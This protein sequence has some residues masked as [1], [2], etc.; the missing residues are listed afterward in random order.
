LS[1][2]TGARGGKIVALKSFGDVTIV[3]KETC[4]G[5]ISGQYATDTGLLVSLKYDVI[6]EE[7]GCISHQSLIE[8][9]KGVIFQSS[10]GLCLIGK[11]LNITFIGAPVEK[12]RDY[13]ITSA[14]ML[15]N[16]QT[17]VF[18]TAD[19]S[20]ICMNYGK[21]AWSTFTG[22]E[23]ISA[24]TVG[25]DYYMLMTDGRILKR[26]TATKTDAGFSI[27]SRLK[28]QWYQLG[29]IGGFERLYSLS[30]QGMV[31]GAH[32]LKVS[33]YYDFEQSPRENLLYATGS[34]STFGETGTFGT[35]II[36]QTKPLQQIRVQPRWQKCTS[37][38]VELSEWVPD[39]YSPDANI[40]WNGVRLE[41]GIKRGAYKFDSSQAAKTLSG[42]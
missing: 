37:V 4:I 19:N 33:M 12:M 23:A 35:V 21:N 1:L 7:V 10:R 3:L 31:E 42:G 34:L 5:V 30:M 27:I 17:V 41:I 26:N 39:D 18:T 9:D 16:I 15:S 24:V 40:V 6:S 14:S 8:I 22:H 28:T 38:S 20:A 29:G 36:D 2:N 11:D 32:G 25:A 13:P